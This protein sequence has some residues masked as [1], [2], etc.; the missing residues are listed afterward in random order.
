MPGRT[1]VENDRLDAIPDLGEVLERRRRICAEDLEVDGGAQAELRA[2]HRG[3]AAVA[4][5]ADGR[6]AGREALRG[7]E[8]RDVDVLVPADPRLALDVQGDPLGEV[9]EPVAEACVHRVLEVRVRV[10]EARDDHRLFV[11]R[12]G[13]ELVGSADRG[14]APVARSRPRRRSIGGPSIGRTQSAERTFTAR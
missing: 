9:A 14:D 1:R 10:D 8:P 12:A 4:A 3:R 11:A 7:S 2:G 6:H 5:V 13:A